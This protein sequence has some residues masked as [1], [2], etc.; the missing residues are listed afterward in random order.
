MATVNLK[1]RYKVGE[2]REYF[3]INTDTLRVYETICQL[4]QV[5]LAPSGDRV[6]D[7]LDLSQLQFIQ[8]TKSKGFSL[9]E[10]G[11]LMG[12][13]EKPLIACDNLRKLTHEK[14]KEVEYHMNELETLCEELTLLISLCRDKNDLGSQY[15]N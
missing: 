9:D 13:G 14:L 4:T 8:H 1:N 10:I 7:Q 15:S 2:L 11:Q 12:M 5:Y 6:Y 3:G